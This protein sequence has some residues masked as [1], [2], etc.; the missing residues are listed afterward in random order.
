MFIMDTWKVVPS[1]DGWSTQGAALLVIH[2]PGDTPAAQALT[3]WLNK[4]VGANSFAHPRGFIRLH[5]KYCYFSHAPGWPPFL[6]IANPG[7]WFCRDNPLAD[8]LQIRAP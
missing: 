1:L 8:T 2:K 6:Y 3:P 7:R 4:L 5:Q